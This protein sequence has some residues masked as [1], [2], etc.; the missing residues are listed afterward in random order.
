MELENI[1]LGIDLGNIICDS[2]SPYSIGKGSIL[3][4]KKNFEDSWFMKKLRE[5]N[6]ENFV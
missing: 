5:K 3:S 1:G 2:N 4:T 6:L